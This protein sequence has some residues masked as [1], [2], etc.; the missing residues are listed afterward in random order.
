MTLATCFLFTAVVWTA[1]FFRTNVI[2][3]EL[4]SPARERLIK[5]PKL[6]FFLFGMP[7]AKNLPKSVMSFDGVWIQSSAIL[8]AIYWWCV[9]QNSWGLG[10]INFVVGVL[11]GFMF[12]FGTAKLLYRFWMYFPNKDV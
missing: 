6:L 5:V 9:W 8:M 12:G 7:R 11:G 1:G 3:H 2:E 4:T 10:G